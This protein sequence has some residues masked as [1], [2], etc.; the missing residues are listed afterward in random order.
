MIISAALIIGLTH[1]A[2][3]FNKN[4]SRKTVRVAIRTDRAR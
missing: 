3:L 4:W 2:V 1:L